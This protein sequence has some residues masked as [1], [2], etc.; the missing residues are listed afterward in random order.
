MTHDFTG[1]A[2]FCQTWQQ[3]L[4]LAELAEKQGCEI[5]EAAFNEEDFNDGAVYFELYGIAVV[6]SYSTQDPIIPYTTFINPPV[7]ESVYGC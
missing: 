5:N 4:H 3:M 1:K 7:D 6:N 2:I